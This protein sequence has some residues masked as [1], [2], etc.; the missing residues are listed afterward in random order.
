L[1]CNRRIRKLYPNNTLVKGYRPM[2]P[3]APREKARDGSATAI[4]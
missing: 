2:A 3:A 1:T 4:K